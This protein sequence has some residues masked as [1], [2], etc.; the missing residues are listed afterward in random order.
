M[1][2]TDTTDTPL[3]N[4]AGVTGG[5]VVSTFELLANETRLAVLLALWEAIEP[6]DGGVLDP[7]E[8]AAV[9]F[10]ELRDRVGM[11]DSGQF[12][13][14]LGKLNGTLVERTDDG[15]L[16]LPAGEKLVRTVISIAGFD[17]VSLDV[18]EI[19]FPCP[20]CGAPTA[21][22]YSNQRLYHLCT[23]CEGTYRLGD[24]HPSGVLSAW[25][26]YPSAL[27]HRTAEEVYNAIGTQGLHWWGQVAAEVCPWCSGEGVLRLD[28]CDEHDPGEEGGCPACGRQYDPAVRFACRVCKYR[29][30]TNLPQWS[31]NHPA[32]VAFYWNL[33][34]GLGY[35]RY[36]LETARWRW[37]VNDIANHEIMSTSPPRAQI[38]FPHEEAEL[39]L[40]YD[41]NMNVVDVKEVK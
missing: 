14:H 22:T 39:T 17:D 33:G 3:E 36:D 37:S 25:A 23:E 26:A 24:K 9:P 4:A 2:P 29:G 13:Y 6:F 20:E 21:I 31:L 15:Y 7:I 10:S 5:W 35:D 27:R 30:Q 11:A 34:I 1:P 8:G 32:V 38:T 18:T 41:E 40:T 19:D 16:L 28:V 12:N